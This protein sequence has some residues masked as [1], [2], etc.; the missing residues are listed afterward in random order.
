MLPAAG[1]L[2]CLVYL[3]RAAYNMVYADYIRLTFSYLPDVWDPAKFFVPDILTRIPVNYL[4][5]GINVTFFGYNTMFEMVLGVLGLGAS[6]LIII[7]YCRLKRLNGII[8]FLIMVVMFSLNKWEMLTNGTGWVHFAAFACFFYHYTVLDRYLVF[9]AGKRSDPV[10][11]IVLPFLITLGI[12]GPYCAIYSLILLLAYGFI[13]ISDRRKKKQNSK[14][15]VIYSIC[16]LIPLLCYILSNSF[17]E[18]VQMPNTESLIS[19]FFA[20]PVYFIKFF[21]ASFASILVGNE[22]LLEHCGKIG[23]YKLIYILGVVVILF[24]LLAL[25]LNFR[26]KLYKKTLLPLIMIISG[27]LNHLLILYSRWRFMGFNYSMD[28]RY[29]LQYQVGIIG[30]LLTFGFLI[31]NKRKRLLIR[32]TAIIFSLLFLA[33]NG[34]TSL[35]E[36]KK[37]PDR[38]DYLMSLEQT[39]LNFEQATAEELADYP[40]IFQ[41]RELDRILDSLQ[42]LK[43]NQLNIFHQ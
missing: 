37:A 42:I 32:S 5:R 38:K 3:N 1:V 41:Y 9:K 7:N 30:I 23:D 12:A 26:F 17:T 14:D 25:Y 8:C 20:M 40:L 19:T 18:Q 29:T 16:V 2:F 31:R 34:Y 28:S 6:A 22:V 33:G 35:K 4:I 15:L 11:L 10:R 36:W 43:D 27:G 13:W 39:A 21:L 24:Y